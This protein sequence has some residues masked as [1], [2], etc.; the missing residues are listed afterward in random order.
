MEPSNY[1][2]YLVTQESLSDG[3]STLEVVEAAVAGGVDVVQLRE[4]GTDTRW[5]YDLGLE[6]REVTAEAGVDL[7]VNDRVDVA[8]A[9][10][11]D[12]VHVGQSDLPVPVAR[13]LLGP[14]A[15]VGCSASTVAEAEAAEADG[16]DYLGV[17]SIYGTTSKDV[18][19]PEDDVGPERV[20]AIADAVSIPIVGIGGVTAE[21]AG[22]VVEAGAAGVAVISEITAA[23]DPAAATDALASTV[24]RTKRQAAERD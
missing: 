2:T 21:N 10:D 16:A 23:D 4:K 22:P 11:A 17:G 19:K 6:V 20:A 14:E 3:R 9:I 24:E 15:V 13:E 1:G 7:I 8:E 18:P 5:R 12:G